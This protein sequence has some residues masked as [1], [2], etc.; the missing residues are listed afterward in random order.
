MFGELKNISGRKILKFSL[1]PVRP[2]SDFNRYH[3]TPGESCINKCAL[4][5]SHQTSGRRRAAGNTNRDRMLGVE[6][7]C[8][9]LEFSGG[10][11]DYKIII[12]M[13]YRNGVILIEIGFDLKIVIH[14][15]RSMFSVP[16]ST[17]ELWP[18]GPP[19]R[20]RTISILIIITV[21][22]PAYP[23]QVSNATSK[24]GLGCARRA[25]GIGTLAYKDMGPGQKCSRTVH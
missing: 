22:W 16:T 1:E 15:R 7:T 23:I 3:S 14:S 24:H 8:Y 6:S 10:Y 18:N 12:V 25:L 21:T 11:D 13:V 19:A 5:S 17:G 9:R 20:P 2:Q 4:A